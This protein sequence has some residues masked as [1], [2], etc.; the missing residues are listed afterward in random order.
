VKYT[1]KD[2]CADFAPTFA[3]VLARNRGSSNI[4]GRKSPTVKGL[5]P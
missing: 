4:N 5:K 3:K 2:G 1:I